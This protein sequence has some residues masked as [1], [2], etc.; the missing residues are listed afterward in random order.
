MK[1]LVGTLLIGAVAAVLA[2]D[3]QNA[4]NR[5]TRG[6]LA[7]NS[8]GATNDIMG[9]MITNAPFTASESGETVRIL[10]DGNRIVQS[11]TGFVA[12]NSQG[13]V[14]REI[15]SGELGDG[16]SR[17]M[18][19]GGGNSPG[20]ISFVAGGGAKHILSGKI[21]A[22]REAKEAGLV[23][24]DSVSSPAFEFG[25]SVAEAPRRTEGKS[26]T[27]TES[28]GMRD[29]DG[30]NAEGVRVVTT[31]PAGSIGNER[32][33]EIVSEAWYSKELGVLVYSNRS[34]PRVGKNT[35]QITNIVQGEPNA[36]LFLKP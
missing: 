19:L 36:G 20:V 7:V 13:L 10:P 16:S 3:A 27:R 1:L 8:A 4:Q 32:D 25:N 31:F 12:R 17:P 23:S 29:F 33:F 22:E 21:V 24:P 5:V 28:L 26:R 11:W 35:Y 15:M 2:Q 18:I 34:D 30:L 14:I 9:K 6:R